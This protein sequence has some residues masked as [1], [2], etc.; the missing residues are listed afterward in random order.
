MQEGEDPECWRSVAPPQS[1][2]LPLALWRN[3]PLVSILDL[4]FHT[5]GLHKYNDGPEL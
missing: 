5:R 4:T 2:L 3:V 1:A